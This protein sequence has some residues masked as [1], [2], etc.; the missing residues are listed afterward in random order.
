MAN[1]PIFI[2]AEQLLVK[3]VAVDG[4]IAPSEP[5]VN[6]VSGGGVT[7]GTS[8]DPTYQ[9]NGNTFGATVVT[10]TVSTTPAVNVE[11]NGTS[12]GNDPHT[13]LNFTGAG[14]TASDSGG[15]VAQVNIPGG[16]TPTYHTSNGLTG[17]SITIP[18]Q[19]LTALSFTITS[20]T[21]YATAFCTATARTGNLGPVYLYL[22]YSLDSGVTWLPADSY[23]EFSGLSHST[24]ITSGQ[25]PYGVSASMSIYV[26][27]LTVGNPIEVRVRIIASNGSGSFVL[28]AL[29]AG[30]LIVQN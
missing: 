5:V 9:V 7:F 24:Q 27:G 26:T 18:G 17:G 21:M 25:S 22:E 6:F 8:D 11:Q 1:P 16:F 3:Q 2:A 20:S 4:A 15:G 14:V 19:N 13:T 28:D 29:N 30:N 23:V 10:A 12:V